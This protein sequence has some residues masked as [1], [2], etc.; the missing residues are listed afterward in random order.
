[1]WLKGHTT[2]KQCQTKSKTNKQKL[3][4]KNKTIGKCIL[5]NIWTERGYLSLKT[6]ETTKGK[7]TKDKSIEILIYFESNS[8]HGMVPF[9]G[10]MISSYYVLCIFFQLAYTILGSTVRSQELQ[11]CASFY[12]WLFPGT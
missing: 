8:L 11:Q 12:S 2:L 6:I 5:L 1:M 10:I 4:M 7:K 3:D 9:V